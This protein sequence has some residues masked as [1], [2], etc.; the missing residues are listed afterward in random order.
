M[1]LDTIEIRERYKRE[2]RELRLALLTRPDLVEDPAD[3]FDELREIITDDDAEID[4]GSDADGNPISTKYVF[5][6][7]VV[8]RSQAEVEE[9]IARMLAAASTGSTNFEETTF[10]EW[11]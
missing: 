4:D 9:E 3:L 2:D 11:M 8:D 10:G 5:D 7:A 6:N 1:V